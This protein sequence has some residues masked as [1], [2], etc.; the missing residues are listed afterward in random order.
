MR[1][2]AFFAW[3]IALFYAYTA[4]DATRSGVVSPMRG[5]TSVELRK[6]DPNSGYSRNVAARWIIASGFVILGIATYVLA[7]HFEKL[8][9]KK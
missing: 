4:V 6:E 9:A 1:I 8:N 2:F 7:G 3:G 5:D